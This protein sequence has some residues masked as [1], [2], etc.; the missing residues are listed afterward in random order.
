[1]NNT[2]QFKTYK[3]LI[4]YQKSTLLT[5]NVINYFSN[6]KLSHTKEF[7][8]VQFLRAIGSIG[9][10]IAEGYGRLNCQKC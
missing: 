5:K 3:N 10:N 4:V 9:A 2:T 7:V 6:F 1:M 8:L